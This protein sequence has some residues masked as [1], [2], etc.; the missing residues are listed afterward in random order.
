M[1]S[2]L[3][4][5]VLAASSGLLL[6]QN[7]PIKMGLWEKTMVTTTGADAPSTM[8][9]RSCVTP[10][11]W[12][13]MVANAS[14]QH[15]GCTID[16]VKTARGYTFSGSCTTTHVTMVMHGSSTVED[17]EHIVSESHTAMTMNGQKK[18]VDSH[19]TSRF[20]GADCG[21]VMPGKPEIEG[22]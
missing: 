14:K 10:A 15:E 16:S 19:S 2:M 17:S 7:A 20:L 21:N 9:A 6:A 5:A 1:R 22:K 4:G 13:E 3:I 8:K 11:T 12:Q 18:Q